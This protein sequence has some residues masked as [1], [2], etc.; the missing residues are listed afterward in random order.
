MNSTHPFRT[1]VVLKGACLFF[2]GVAL[3]LP[4]QAISIERSRARPRWSFEGP[5][6]GANVIARTQSQADAKTA[7]ASRILIAG[8]KMPCRCPGH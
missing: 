1:D 4:V 2:A 6:N 5:T 8:R 3:L 7:A